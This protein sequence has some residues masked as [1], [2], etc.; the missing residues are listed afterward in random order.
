MLFARLSI[1]DCASNC[2]L[3]SGWIAWLKS[4]MDEWLEQALKWHGM[5]CHDL[6]VMCLTPSPPNNPDRV[7]L[8][9]YSTS[10]LSHI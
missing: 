1:S 8:G 7:E 9:V 3:G 5:Y 2:L 10:V 4:L 6:E